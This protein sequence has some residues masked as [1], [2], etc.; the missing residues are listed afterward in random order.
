MPAWEDFNAK[1]T[2]FVGEITYGWGM[3]MHRRLSITSRSSVYR[4]LS[5]SG[6]IKL[7]NILKIT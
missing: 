2:I 4:R 1:G 3:S 6:D 5:K 7:G